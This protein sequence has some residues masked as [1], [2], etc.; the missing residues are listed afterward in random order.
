MLPAVL[1]FIIPLL[2]LLLFGAVPTGT[3]LEEETEF[4]GEDEGEFDEVVVVVIPGR[5]WREEE[6]IT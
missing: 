4:D 6:G 2:L 3:E 5:R 1:L